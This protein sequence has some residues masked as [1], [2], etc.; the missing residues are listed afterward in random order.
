L[1]N[2]VGV[3]ARVAEYTGVNE[4]AALN[5]GH[6]LRDFALQKDA[7]LI[8]TPISHCAASDPVAIRMVL[9]EGDG[10]DALKAPIDIVRAIG[11][12][13]VVV[14][15]SYHAGVFALAQGISVVGLANSPYY[16]AK[17]AGLRAQF[18]TGIHIVHP[19]DEAGLRNAINQ[20]WES[21][22]DEALI[23]AAQSQV[24]AS[25]AAFER[26]KREL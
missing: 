9:G 23:E 17:F 18:G 6:I 13:R 4:N 11:K 8:P 7:P 15:A 21:A 26:F 5:L 16:D 24:D 20:A 25:L 3:N 19:D 22:P 10:G 2:G 14:T 1:A 12:C